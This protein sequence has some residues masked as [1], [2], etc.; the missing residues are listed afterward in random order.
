MGVEMACDA[1]LDQR[2]SG[3]RR[4]IPVRTGLRSTNES[5]RAGKP[6]RCTWLVIKH[7]PRS[8]TPASP[9][10]CRK[11]RR[12][13]WRP[14]SEEKV[15]RRSTPRCVMWQATPGSTHR[16]RRGMV[17]GIPPNGMRSF[18]KNCAVQADPFP[19]LPPQI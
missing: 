19:P 4:T 16:F 11:C 7:H 12:Y 5:S 6:I 3:A 18:L 14:S 10:V 9:K 2:Q 8:L 15:S 13:V 1:A 17:L